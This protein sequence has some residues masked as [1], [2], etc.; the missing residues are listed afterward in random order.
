[1]VLSGSSSV[2]ATRSAESRPPASSQSS[3]SR[4]AAA[5]LGTSPPDPMARSGL[6]SK[7][8]I[9]SVGFAHWRPHPLLHQHLLRPQHRRRHLLR[10]RPQLQLREYRGPS[11]S[12]SSTA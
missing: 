3:L 4:R 2:L 1:M 10:R 8:A 7:S 6:P 5:P 12:A 11:S 9:I